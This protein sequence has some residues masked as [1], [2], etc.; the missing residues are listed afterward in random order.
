MPA[1]SVCI[2]HLQ[3]RQVTGARSLHSCS[4][5]LPSCPSRLCC[6]AAVLVLRSH[7]SNWAALCRMD[8]QNSCTRLMLVQGLPSWGRV[9]ARSRLRKPASP[10]LK[11]RCSLSCVAIDLAAPCRL[12]ADDLLSASERM[13]ILDEIDASDF[14]ACSRAGNMLTYGD[15]KRDIVQRWI[16]DAG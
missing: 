11:S 16:H 8:G 2:A 3:S 4:N 10:V 6:C 7:P 12:Q 15:C 9:P 1:F 5:V 14:A 13:R